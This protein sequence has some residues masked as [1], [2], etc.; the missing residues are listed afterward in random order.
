MLRPC[1]LVSVLFVPFAVRLQAIEPESVVPAFRGEAFPLVVPGARALVEVLGADVDAFVDDDDVAEALAKR[2]GF[3]A[4]EQAGQK[5]VDHETNVRRSYQG[6]KKKILRLPKAGVTD[7]LT[8]A[9]RS[10][11]AKALEI[12]RTGRKLSAREAAEELRCSYVALRAWEQGHYRPS[13]P[14]RDAIA[15]WSHGAVPSEGWGATKGAAK[16]RARLRTVGT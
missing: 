8:M 10:D 3:R 4:R 15:R 1:G 9:N 14:Y 12:H 5:N 2:A 13:E 11:S 7:A 16:L 6:R